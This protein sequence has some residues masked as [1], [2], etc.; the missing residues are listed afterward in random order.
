M[1]TEIALPAS[2]SV[3]FPI[4][5]IGLPRA[6]RGR[7]SREP[8]MT[9]WVAPLQSEIE[10]RSIR[11]RRRGAGLLVPTEVARGFRDDFARHSD[12]MSLGFRD[13]VARY[14]N[15]SF[16]TTPLKRR[17][18]WNSAIRSTGWNQDPIARR[19]VFLKNRR[20]APQMRQ[21]Q[22]GL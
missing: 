4:I 5:G 22:K 16:E 11:C 9:A 14:P 17:V 13:E 1:R 7:R 12:L 15:G 2:Y 8:W 21:P 18:G 6:I 10:D 19:R 3:E 20:S